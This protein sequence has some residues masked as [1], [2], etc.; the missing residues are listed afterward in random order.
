MVRSSIAHDILPPV[1]EIEAQVARIGEQQKL[2]WILSILDT[3]GG[4]LWKKNERL[5]KRTKIIP[6]LKATNTS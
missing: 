2:S 5:T 3:Q 4:S 1:L 6:P